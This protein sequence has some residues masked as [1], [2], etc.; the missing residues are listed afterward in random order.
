[1]KKKKVRQT[2]ISGIIHIKSTFNNT[3]ITITDFKG[4]TLSWSS[5]GSCN[6]KGTRKATAFAGQKAVA[7]AIKV[8]RNYGLKRV[9][10]HVSGQG[11]GRESA[12]R[13]IKSTG[14]KVLLLKDVT[15]IPYNGCRPPNR[16]R[17]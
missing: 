1:M 17:V 8:A 7:E 14:L 3:I 9:K 15:G 11:P 13:T 12:L 2:V 4:N 10:V 6:F 5:G 16:R